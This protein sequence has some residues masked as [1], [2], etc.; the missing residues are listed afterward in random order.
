M[1]PSFY[2]VSQFPRLARIAAQWQIIRDEFLLLNRP[3]MNIHRSGKSREEVYRELML[4]IQ[5]GKQFGWLLGWGKNGANPD[6]LAYPLIQQNTVIP[7]ITT[8]MQKT[9]A[10]FKELSGIKV[11]SLLKMKPNTFL[12]THTH[13]EIRREGL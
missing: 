4:E 2:D 7:F 3:I 8:E 5:S 12:P 1:R 13:P 10:M 9:I 11:C 6:W